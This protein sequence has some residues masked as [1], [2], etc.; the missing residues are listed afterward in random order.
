[1][2]S[3]FRQACFFH[4]AN[5]VKCPFNIPIIEQHRSCQQ[6][7]VVL[8]AQPSK[9]WK[10]EAKPPRPRLRGQ[11]R[12]RCQHASASWP[13][14]T[15]NKFPCRNI[16][17]SVVAVSASAFGLSNT[18]REASPPLPPPPP[19]TDRAKRPEK[20]TSSLELQVFLC[21]ILDGSV[22]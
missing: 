14:I 5:R 18:M 6:R 1:M 13:C 22:I 10:L 16:M 7:C 21:K 2:R 3:S 15:R 19:S 12:A 11:E 20:M 4:A 9:T 8:C 17:Y